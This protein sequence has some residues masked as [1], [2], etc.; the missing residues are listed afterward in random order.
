MA[1]FWDI[2]D[3]HGNKTGRLHERGK[4]MQDGEYHLSV[5]IWI[6]NSRGEFL[7]SRRAPTKNNP[8]IWEPTGGSALAGEESLDAALRETKEE[9]G[10]A[11]DPQNGQLFTSYTWPHSDGC[12]AACIDVWLFRQD[13]VLTDVALQPEET[14][15]ATWAGKEEIRHLIGKKQFVNFTYLDALFALT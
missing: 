10:L 3:A 7:I 2:R 1:E 13:F 14:C 9:L 8:N 6:V 4:P 15:D 11:L 5:S 12:G